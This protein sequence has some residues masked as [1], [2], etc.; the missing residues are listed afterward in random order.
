MVPELTQQHEKYV[1]QAGVVAIV[2]LSLYTI[3]SLRTNE[4][5]EVVE[6]EREKRNFLSPSQDD[7]KIKT[8]KKPK[9]NRKQS[10]TT[11]EKK[12]ILHAV[13]ESSAS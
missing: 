3:T 11:K 1:V 13:S 5:E 7:E 2:S 6:R 12:E 9:K 8:K 10:A 4:K